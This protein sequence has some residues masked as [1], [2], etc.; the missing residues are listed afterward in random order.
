MVQLSDLVIFCI[1]RFL[2][3]EHGYRDTWTQDAKNFYAKCFDKIQARVRRKNIIE[4]NERALLRL[5]EYLN[6][7]KCVPI[8]QW[9]RKYQI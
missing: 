1:R 2:E 7:V 4:R 3:I 6:E 5:K 9:K 8:G